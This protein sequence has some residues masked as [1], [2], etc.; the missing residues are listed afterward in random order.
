MSDFKTNV[1]ENMFRPAHW[2]MI[3]VFFLFFPSG[4]PF[5]RWAPLLVVDL[6]RPSIFHL[7]LASLLGVGLLSRGLGQSLVLGVGEKL[8][9]SHAGE[10]YLS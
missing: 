7:G 10:H 2:A 5:R 8:E 1:P 9:T 3:N 4:L 6:G